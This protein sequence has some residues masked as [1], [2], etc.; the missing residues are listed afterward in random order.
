MIVRVVV[1]SGI[2]QAGL[3]EKYSGRLLVILRLVD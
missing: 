2:T 1:N 3:V